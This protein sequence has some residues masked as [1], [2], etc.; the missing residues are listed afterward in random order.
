MT[1]SDLQILIDFRSEVAEPDDETARRV[2]ARATAAAAPRDR[3]A[4]RAPR[5]HR[6]RLALGVVTAA[7]VLVPTAV[8]FGGKIVDLFEG[9]PAPPEVS[10]DFTIFNRMAGLAIQQGF[11]ETMPEADVSKA[12]G[13]IEIQ[14]PDG[15]EDLWAAPNDQGGQCYFVDFANDPPRLSGKPGGGGCFTPADAYS[16]SKIDPEGP[17]WTIEHP[18]LLT[19]D[20]SVA[21]DATTVHI[22][23]RDGSILTAPVIEHF[24]LVSIPK[25][26]QS[27]DARLERVTAFDEAGNQVADWTPPQ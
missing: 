7:L 14:T 16:Y 9:T 10:T 27:G 1:D 6:S 3:T 20:G 26:A 11:S 17:G 25:P 8:A 18:D 13:V 4:L 22:M 15:P 2:Y 23:L 24:F 21:V 12:H 5:L 19:I